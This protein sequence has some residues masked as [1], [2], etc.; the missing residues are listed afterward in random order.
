MA[1]SGS[2]GGGVKL[3][4][5]CFARIQQQHAANLA[6]FTAA[7]ARIPYVLRLGCAHGMRHNLPR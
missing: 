5:R 7:L 1:G 4:P 6:A 2:R 3:S